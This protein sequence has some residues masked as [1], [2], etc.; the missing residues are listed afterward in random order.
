[1]TVQNVSRLIGTL[2]QHLSVYAN[3]G[4]APGGLVRN[5]SVT[6]LSKLFKDEAGYATASGASHTA[7]QLGGV[8][9]SRGL[10]S[11][12][13][14]RPV[15]SIHPQISTNGANPFAPSDFDVLEIVASMPPSSELLVR[16][17]GTLLDDE[18]ATLRVHAGR[19]DSGSKVEDGASGFVNNRT[20]NMHV[21]T[22][23]R[24][25]W[26]S[27]LLLNKCHTHGCWLGIQSMRPG[28]GSNRT[29]ARGILT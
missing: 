25:L 10:P 20:C 26:Q 1:M 15:R 28:H 27:R 16:R 29:R 7:A 18:R 14:P 21:N 11:I 19:A 6:Y 8:S 13:P 17:V 3:Y 2:P 24:L 12:M 4:P 22:I 5:L 23:V 9:R